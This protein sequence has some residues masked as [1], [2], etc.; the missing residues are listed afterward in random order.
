MKTL[1]RIAAL[2]A[3]LLSCFGA[4]AQ[5]TP[6]R[7]EPIRVGVLQYGTVNWELDAMTREGLDTANGVDVEIVPFAGEAASS[8]ALQAGDV[9]MIVADWLWVSRQRATGADFTFAPYSTSVGSL[10]VPQNSPAA[11]L[12][13]LTGKTIG[14]A[15]GPLDKNWLLIQAL[16]KREYGV[17]LSSANEIVYGAP[18]LL[19]EKA[20]TGELDAV[21]NFWH[22]AARLEASGFRTLISGTEAAREMG[23]E[24]PVASIGWVFRD[25]F[26]EE[27]PEAIDGFLAADLATKD[28]LTSSDAAWEPLRTMM[29][30]E[31]DAAYRILIQRYRDGIPARS[32]G[33]EVKDTEALYALLYEIGGERL[34]G[35]SETLVEGT[36][37]SGLG[38]GP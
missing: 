35:P 22:Y 4:L 38:N 34:V 11:D 13:D 24:G 14:V 18:P 2:A 30:A 21:L 27:H 1:M 16:A 37:Y 36:Y 32:P 20:R 9:D 6:S 17:D 12:G 29:K 25:S 31:D 23:T 7:V 3:G 33:D 15:G 26:A 28:L 8:V 5:E 10:M 19:T